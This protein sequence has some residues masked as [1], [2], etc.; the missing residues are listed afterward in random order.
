[1]DPSGR[2][3]EDGLFLCPSGTYFIF[4]LSF[5]LPRRAF[6]PNSKV[7]KESAQARKTGSRRG[8]NLLQLA[9][10]KFLALIDLL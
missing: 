9:L 4:L 1:V 8:G 6:P 2:G 3:V 5:R 10:E 7:N